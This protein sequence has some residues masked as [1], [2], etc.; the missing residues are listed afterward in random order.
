V[1]ERNRAD[2][3]VG[4]LRARLAVLTRGRGTRTGHGG[5]PVRLG[6][7]RSR[8]EAEERL[9]TLTQRRLF[10]RPDHHA[11]DD[12]QHRIHAELRYL[13]RL[14]KERNRYATE[15]ERS[16]TRLR[17]TERA[18]ERIPEVETA[19]S[20]R[21]AWFRSH[22]EELAWEAD[23]ATRLAETETAKP[24]TPG[25]DDPVIDEV[26]ED[27][28]KSIDLRTIDLSPTRPRTGI[29]RQLREA[30]GIGPDDPVNLPLP[31]LPGRGIDGPDLGL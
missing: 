29:E 19:I 30:L 22:P 6:V 9:A 18:V 23:L 15:L 7:R 24:P 1:P 5:G 10:R 8:S 13:E 2:P 27:T 26:L 25:R 28:L 12:T 17:D 21:R 3:S 11:I 16:R 14:E 31:P 20:R 4:R